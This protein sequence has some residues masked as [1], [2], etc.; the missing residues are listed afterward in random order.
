MERHKNKYGKRFDFD[1][2]NKPPKRKVP[3]S[4]K[5]NRTVS[6]TTSTS[7]SNNGKARHSE[8]HQNEYM[9]AIVERWNGTDPNELFDIK[10]WKKWIQR[11]ASAKNSDEKY[12]NEK[13]LSS[14]AKALMSLLTKESCGYMYRI[15]KKLDGKRAQEFMDLVERFEHNEIIKL[16]ANVNGKGSSTEDEDDESEDDYTEE[17]PI[18]S[19]R[20]GNMDGEDKNGQR[21]AITEAVLKPSHGCRPGLIFSSPH[22]SPGTPKCETK[23]F[24]QNEVT[25]CRRK[26]SLSRRSL[27][28]R[29]KEGDYKKRISIQPRRP[30]TL[31]FP[32]N[33]LCQERQRGSFNLGLPKLLESNV[34]PDTASGGEDVIIENPTPPVSPSSFLENNQDDFPDIECNRRQQ[35]PPLVLETSMK[36]YAHVPIR[37]YAVS[38]FGSSYKVDSNLPSESNK[39]QGVNLRANNSSNAYNDLPLFASGEPKNSSVVHASPLDDDFELPD[40]TSPV[41]QNKENF[42]VNAEEILAK[43]PKPISAPQLTVE[44]FQEIRR[45]LEKPPKEKVVSG[46]SLNIL[47]EDLAIFSDDTEWLIDLNMDFYLELIKERSKQ[48]GYPSVYIFHSFFYT[49]LT[50][51]EGGYSAVQEATGEDDIFKYDL[52]FFP[53]NL[54]QHWRLVVVQFPKKI[55]QCLDSMVHDNSRILKVIVALPVLLQYN[56][57]YLIIES[58]FLV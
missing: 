22:G 33:S 12:S 7:F 41:D 5:D 21:S 30:S 38:P 35:S 11:E 24:G 32:N 8:G 45:A 29:N 16:M 26:P 2:E 48:H 9:T 57:V 50:R 20:L 56:T 28:N 14:M 40:I 17:P 44:M 46:F 43:Y 3:P 13:A 49:L 31:Q 10:N 42:P 55:I 54:N 47:Q 36:E 1:L 51:E 53:V 19:P 52:V 58:G 4:K 6:P 25:P 37:P 18:K 39:K 15:H 23:P 34:C 27:S